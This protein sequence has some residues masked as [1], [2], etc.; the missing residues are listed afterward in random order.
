LHTHKTRRQTRIPHSICG[1]SSHHR[2]A[3]VPQYCR[4]NSV[5]RTK[6]A[7]DCPNHKDAIINFRTQI[8]FGLDHLFVGTTT[9]V[10]APVIRPA[11]NSVSS[12]WAD[13]A[14]A[15]R[16]QRPWCPSPA[17]RYSAAERPT[18]A[19]LPPPRARTARWSTH[20]APPRT[21]HHHNELPKTYPQL[22]FV[23][24]QL[25]VAVV[26]EERCGCRRQECNQVEKISSRRA[27]TPTSAAAVSFGSAD[28]GVAPR[29]ARPVA[30]GEPLPESK[31][32]SWKISPLTPSKEQASRSQACP[33][34][35]SRRVLNASQ[36][37]PAA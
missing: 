16:P 29:H 12:P 2:P 25:L 14:L 35:S 28:I 10:V 37:R 31:P 20:T 32:A 13:G 9:P 5:G 24:R 18:P 17:S 26:E 27:A 19:P 23:V 8:H 30:V 15:R 34:R 33:P 36:H 21:P 7:Q 4:S 6:F 11:S 3:A 1:H 22:S